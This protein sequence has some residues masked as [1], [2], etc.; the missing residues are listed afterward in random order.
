MNKNLFKLN[1]LFLYT[2]PDSRLDLDDKPSEIHVG[3]I[4]RVYSNTLVPL[5]L[6]SKKYKIYLSFIKHLNIY[7]VLIYLVQC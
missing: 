6:Y 1:N 3:G 2:V 7:S 5:L 4:L